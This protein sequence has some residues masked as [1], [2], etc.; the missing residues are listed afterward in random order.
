MPDENKES[1]F[2]TLKHPAQKQTG[3]LSSLARGSERYSR[4]KQCHGSPSHLQ[5][6]NGRVPDMNEPQELPT[7]TV[8]LVI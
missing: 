1:V 6:I 7:T 4:R 2:L 8:L 5:I 3:N